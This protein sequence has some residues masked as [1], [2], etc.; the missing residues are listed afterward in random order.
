MFSIKADGTRFLH[1][2]RHTRHAGG[3]NGMAASELPHLPHGQEC[4]VEVPAIC[5]SMSAS[6]AFS[7][8]E[9]PFSTGWPKPAAPGHAD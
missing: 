8:P 1:H 3:H 5:F 2:A 4:S 9:L 6:G 7:G